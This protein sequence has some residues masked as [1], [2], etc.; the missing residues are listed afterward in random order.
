[1]TTTKKTARKNAPA[2]KA[3]APAAKGTKVNPAKLLA[4]GTSVISHTCAEFEVSR[5]LKAAGG[6]Q[7][8]VRAYVIAA[9][10]G[11]ALY[12]KGSNSLDTAELVA[13]GEAVVA[14]PNVNSTKSNRRT[15]A[16][17]KACT[18]A[19]VYWSRALKAADIVTDEARGGANNK[20]KAKTGANKSDKAAANTASTIAVPTITNSVEGHAF[21]QQIA[22]LMITAAQKNGKAFDV[23]TQNLIASFAAGAAKLGHRDAPKPVTK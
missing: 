21:A 18:A 15:A 23:D 1:M 4:L 12:G 19:R 6:N 5:A 17:E 2:T 7:P 16:Q 22:A 13:K 11:A 20:G 14:R 10:V 9:R 8:A 3:V